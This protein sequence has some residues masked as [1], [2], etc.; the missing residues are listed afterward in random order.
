MPIPDGIAGDD[1]ARRRIVEAFNEEYRKLF[2]RTVDGVPVEC[3]TW[4]TAVS[5]RPSD[6]PIA[7][8]GD[9]SSREIHTSAVR[10]T[11]GRSRIS[12]TPVYRRNDLQPARI[13][14]WT[15]NCRGSSV[16]N[17]RSG[18]ADKFHLDD[19]ANLIVELDVREAG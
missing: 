12:Q 16:D 14:R 11:S 5:S 13:L 2:G 15:G 7:P 4:R 3:V 19:F 18:P 1:S 9:R 10:L 17:G 8:A 6:L